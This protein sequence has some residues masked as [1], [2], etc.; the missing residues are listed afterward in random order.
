MKIVEIHQSP[1]NSSCQKSLHWEAK[2]MKSDIKIE[3][4]CRYKAERA[5]IYSK[6]STEF[7]QIKKPIRGTD[8][9]LSTLV[10]TARNDFFLF[11]Y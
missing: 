10:S 4:K 3:K 11:F 8:A 2:E 1:G 7:N 5:A 6:S 9:E